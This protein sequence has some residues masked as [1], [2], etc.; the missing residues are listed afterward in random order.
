MSH[1]EA[2]TCRKYIVPK[3]TEAGWESEPHSIAEQRTFTDGRIIV[4]GG[5]VR[6][7]KQKRA[8]YL[9]RY[10]RDFP[11]AVVEAKPEYK[12]SSAGL[13]QAKDY[14]HT[15]GLKFAYST[16][17]HGIVEFD[18]TSGF[19]REL[20]TF[21]TPDE[22]WSRL[23]AADSITD[24]QAERLLH[25]YHLLP[26]K[27]PRYYQDIAIHQVVQSIVQGKRRVLVTMAT[28]TGKTLSPFRSAGSF[29]RQ[30]LEPYGRTQTS[31]DPLPRR[32]QHLSR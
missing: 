8:D 27:K 17:G 21:P 6:R 24:D 10:T 20:A 4:A 5:K 25:A 30:S 18:F 32:P 19:E 9:L 2:D 16:N 11:I 22:L 1:S 14:A 23:R 31:Q 29:G 3:L 26:G 7:G 12:T 13:G 28:G 15:L